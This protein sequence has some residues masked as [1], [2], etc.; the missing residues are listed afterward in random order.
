MG[1]HARR[2]RLCRASVVERFEIPLD[3]RDW[4]Q[5]MRTPDLKV[6]TIRHLFAEATAD[7]RET[8]AIV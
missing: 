5:R 2:R 6:E 3:G 7:Q 1:R 8:F 4:V